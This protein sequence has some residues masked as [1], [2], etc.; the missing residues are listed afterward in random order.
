MSGHGPLFYEKRDSASAPLGDRPEGR[1]GKSRLALTSLRYPEH[2]QQLSTVTLYA[3]AVIMTEPDEGAPAP[4]K[5]S[6][7]KRAAWQD[8]PTKEGEDMFS[9]ASEF[10]SIV[11]EQHRLSEE[12]RRKASEEKKRRLDGRG[13]KKRRKVSTDG[14]EPIQPRSGSASSA[15]ATRAGSK[16]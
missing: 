8:A 13:D 15:R 3:S 5:R 11:A 1:A 6:F 7:F 2:G 4:K 12:K 16:A 14:E 10:T 9:H